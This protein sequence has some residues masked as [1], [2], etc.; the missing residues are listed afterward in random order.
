M[1]SSRDAS[2]AAAGS[3]HQQLEQYACTISGHYHE[4]GF[5]DRK[6][7][8]QVVIADT[9][10]HNERYGD[11]LQGVKEGKEPAEPIDNITRFLQEPAEPLD[12]ESPASLALVV[13]L[14]INPIAGVEVNY[15][16]AGDTSQ[17]NKPVGTQET[18]EVQRKDPGQWFADDRSNNILPV[19]IPIQPEKKKLMFGALIVH[20]NDEHPTAHNLPADE[21]FFF[22]EFRSD[23]TSRP[24]REMQWKELVNKQLQRV[25]GQ[26]NQEL[27]NNSIDQGRRRKVLQAQRVLEPDVYKHGSAMFKFGHFQEEFTQKDAEAMV[28]EVEM[29]W[30]TLQG[31]TAARLSQLRQGLKAINDEELI[32]FRHL[33]AFLAESIYLMEPDY[34]SISRKALLRVKPAIPL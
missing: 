2:P 3:E 26:Q 24:V 1:Q 22:A 10:V 16:K 18:T 13:G 5:E 28:E 33:R 14:A 9:Y 19:V 12:T 32:D 27:H 7:H 21:I 4:H 6:Q 20:E 11:A 8:H 34:E 23:A 25:L 30:P 31:V 17:R 29:L 15:K